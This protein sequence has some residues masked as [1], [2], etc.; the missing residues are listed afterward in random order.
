MYVQRSMQRQNH[1]VDEQVKIAKNKI[2]RL[3]EY[4]WQLGRVQ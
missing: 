1:F 2:T 3:E 4:C